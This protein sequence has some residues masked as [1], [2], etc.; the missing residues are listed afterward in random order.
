MS[1]IYS[2]GRYISLFLLLFAFSLSGYASQKAESQDDPKEEQQEVKEE[3]KES[4]PQVLV[5]D[6][7]KSPGSTSYQ[8]SP[9]KKYKVKIRGVVPSKIT[10]YNITISN[11]FISQVPLTLLGST[12]NASSTLGKALGV[13]A[14]TDCSELQKQISVTEKAN[15]ESDYLKEITALERMLQGKNYGASCND[16]LKK[17]TDLISE[18]K[19]GIEYEIENV[20]HGSKVT[21]TITR[22]EGAKNLK[23]EVVYTT[24]KRGSWDFAY[25][26]FLQWNHWAKEEAYYLEPQATSGANQISSF[27]IRRSNNRRTLSFVPTVMFYYTSAERADE[28]WRFGLTGGLGYDLSN[29]SVIG[30]IHL[31]FADNLT[32]NAGFVYSQVQLLKGVYKEGQ[33]INE[34]LTSESLH[35]KY[36][37]FNP[38]IGISFRL[39]KPLFGGGNRV[40]PQ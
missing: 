13:A 26:P 31:T 14:I 16:D 2:R 30:G 9:G 15:T 5:I 24:S 18:F 34:N 36:Y 17:A 32:F 21:V 29:L 38:I 23:T 27:I 8:I 22:S 25:G 12:E 3:K 33:T 19:N 20:K 6:L 11:V 35:E 1:Q 4:K 39:D 37:R 10:D 40:N 7:N 28:E